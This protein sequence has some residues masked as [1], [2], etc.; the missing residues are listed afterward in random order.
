[1][2]HMAFPIWHTSNITYD[3]MLY[4]TLPLLLSHTTTKIDGYH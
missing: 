3:M 4:D 2:W 1:M